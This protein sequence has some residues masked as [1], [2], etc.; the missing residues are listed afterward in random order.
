MIEHLPSAGRDHTF[1]HYPFCFVEDHQMGE[2]S[3]QLAKSVP[4]WEGASLTFSIS[5]FIYML[6]HNSI[7]LC[8]FDRDE[9]ISRASY[10]YSLVIFAVVSISSI[11]RLY[12]FDEN[13][14]NLSLTGF[15][16][17][18]TLQL[19]LMISIF[20]IQSLL[21]AASFSNTCLEDQSAVLDTMIWIIH[22]LNV[23][24]LASLL[25]TAAIFHRVM[26]GIQKSDLKND[27]FSPA[28]KSHARNFTTLC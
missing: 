28:Q 10:Y 22:F 13:R 25:A 3:Y 27:G 20:V 24:L 21:E 1:D 12:I 5:L 11:I 4:L 8:A 7:T 2:I 26:D 19:I 23:V 15:F 16:M 18:S 14:L 17:L 9:S 6:A